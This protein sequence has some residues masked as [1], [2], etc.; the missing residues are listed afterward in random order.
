[1]TQKKA[2]ENIIEALGHHVLARLFICQWLE[3]INWHGECAQLWAA[4]PQMWK[5]K[6]DEM[7]KVIDSSVEPDHMLPFNRYS[8]RL[9]HSSLLPGFVYTFGWGIDPQEWDSDGSGPEFVK[10]LEAMIVKE[11]VRA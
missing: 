5:D 9:A 8:F 2:L 6:I 4:L 7:A 3:D 10:E 11:R 1:M